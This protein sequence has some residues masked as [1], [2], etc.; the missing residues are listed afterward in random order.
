MVTGFPLP[1]KPAKTIFIS[2]GRKRVLSYRYVYYS[3]FY[4]SF[5]GVL[6]ALGTRRCTLFCPLPSCHRKISPA[7]A[8]T[9][10]DSPPPTKK[11]CNSIRKLECRIILKKIN[12]AWIV[13]TRMRRTCCVS[14]VVLKL[15]LQPRI[16]FAGNVID[17]Y[18]MHGS[19]GCMAKEREIGMTSGYSIFPARPVTI[20]TG[21]ALNHWRRNL[22]P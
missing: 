5:F 8:A 9:Q 21:L 1:A 7:P 11:S 16:N 6:L 10:I 22:P 2:L 20:P 12:G 19:L 14:Q 18:I 4:S 17:P 13:M 3:F 15:I